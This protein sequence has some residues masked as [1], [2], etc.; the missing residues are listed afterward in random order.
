MPK[1]IQKRNHHEEKLIELIKSKPRKVQEK[2]SLRFSSTQINVVSLIILGATF[3]VQGIIRYLEFFDKMEYVKPWFILIIFSI[4]FLV[5]SVISVSFENVFSPL[6]LKR[7]FN[8]VGF[9][10]FIVGFFIFL[11]SLFFLLFII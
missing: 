11:I 9:L 1:K 5:I 10:C 3:L 4:I 7:A 8:I 6:K 2:F